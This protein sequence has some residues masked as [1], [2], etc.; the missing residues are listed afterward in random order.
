MKRFTDTEKWR[1]P[2]YRELPPRLKCLWQ[3]FCDTCD[4]A[5]VFQ[6]DWKL[7]SFEIGEKV[8]PSD[9]GAFK[10]RLEA[11]P[12]GRFLIRKY[13]PFQSGVLSETC[14]AHKPIL[15][16]VALH[17]LERNGIGYHYPNATLC[18]IPSHRVQ[19]EEKRKETEQ[20]DGG[21]GEGL[22]IPEHLK[23][24]QEFLNKWE[25]WMKIRRAKK[26]CKDFNAM[27]QEQLDWLSAYTVPQAIETLSQS[28]RGNWQGLFEPKNGTSNGKLAPIDK[29]IL[30][31]E[32][33]L[34]CARLTT[35]RSQYDGHQ[36]WSEK[37]KIE[38]HKLKP[39]LAEINSQLGC[40]L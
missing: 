1:D 37:D 39:R 16:L 17:G 18:G 28:I 2:W 38:A 26:S 4:H 40:L 7:A 21:V 12:S 8:T 24:N 29:A 20:K 36:S 25:S 5:G 6:I 15:K 31:K 9:L 27:F 19:E 13:I 23:S 30:Q 35:L 32:K 34:I 3:F 33:D 11:L 10:D 22:K 14:P